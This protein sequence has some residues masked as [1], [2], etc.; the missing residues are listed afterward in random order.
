MADVIVTHHRNKPVRPKRMASQ[1]TI[2]QRQKIGS[3]ED[4]QIRPEQSQK[5]DVIQR[6][7][8]YAAN[9]VFVAVGPR[10]GDIVISLFIPFVQR[11][12]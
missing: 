1:I 9:V 8:A 12:D 3:Y 6:V 4:T 10:V 2:V 5:P 11:F 7:R